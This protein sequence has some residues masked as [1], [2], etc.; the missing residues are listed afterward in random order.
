M[1]SHSSERGS[2]RELSRWAA[3]TR[4]RAK[5]QAD[6]N[7]VYD[8]LEYGRPVDS[9]DG[10]TFVG[11]FAQVRRYFV[12][13]AICRHPVGLQG[14]MRI[15]AIYAPDDALSRRSLRSAPRFASGTYDR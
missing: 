5:R 6:A 12:E 10:V 11:C 14:L 1:S 3:R 4:T 7:N 15:R 2:L 8:A 13:A 9:E